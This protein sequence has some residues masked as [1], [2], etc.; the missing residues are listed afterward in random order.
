MELKLLDI[1]SEKATHPQQLADLEEIRRCALEVLHVEE[2]QLRESGAHRV[3]KTVLSDI[4]Q[5]DDAR[6][7]V[8]MLQSRFCRRADTAGEAIGS[9]VG[10][11]RDELN[12]LHLLCDLASQHE[13]CRLK[14]LIQSKEQL[15]DGMESFVDTWK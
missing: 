3:C 2:H 5:S 9:I 6:V 12:F 15:V 11:E 8:Y 1:A 7:R 10:F 14:P 13:Q 4:E